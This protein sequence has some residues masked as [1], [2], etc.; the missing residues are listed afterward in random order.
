[1]AGTQHAIKD[2]SNTKS[3]YNTSIAGAGR[4]I[5][6]PRNCMTYRQA[7]EFGRGLDQSLTQATRTWSG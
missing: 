7:A 4:I 3:L 6:T 1:M 5:T 2:E